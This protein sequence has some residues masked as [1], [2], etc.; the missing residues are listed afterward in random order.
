MALKS[1][2]VDEKSFDISYTIFNPLAKHDLV[3]LHGWGANKELMINSFSSTLEDFRHVYIDLPGFGKSSNDYVLSVTLYSRIIKIFLEELGFSTFAILGHSYGGKVATLLNPK[4]LILLS[5]AGIIEE[6]SLEVKTKIF[7]SKILKYIGLGFL[8]KIFRS[9]DV[10]SMSEVMYETFKNAISENLENDF[11]N[12]K[13]KA[14]LFWGEYDTA[15]TMKAAN[16]ISSLISNSTLV[17]YKSDHYFF[18]KNA[19]DIGERIKNGIL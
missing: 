2:K 17:T 16:K 19:K 1:I 6:K 11:K 3:V 12:Y 5:T 15:T 9:K 13:G 10:S 8:S 4:H 18:L 7:F 14:L